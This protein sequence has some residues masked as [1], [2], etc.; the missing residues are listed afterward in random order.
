MGLGVDDLGGETSF[1]GLQIGIHWMMS[2]L[3]TRSMSDSV[4]D[5]R[6]QHSTWHLVGAQEIVIMNA[7]IIL[8]FNDFNHSHRLLHGP[9][10]GLVMS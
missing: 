9:H 3:Q 6:T 2:P 4:L 5:P 1:L 8:I 7:L 10:L